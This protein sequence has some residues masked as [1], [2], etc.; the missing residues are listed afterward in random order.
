MDK[1]VIKDIKTFK[2]FL[3]ITLIL[4]GQH[5]DQLFHNLV[6]PWA[7]PFLPLHCFRRGTLSSEV[8]LEGRNNVR[9]IKAHSLKQAFDFE[10]LHEELCSFPD[11][12]CLHLSYVFLSNSTLKLNGLKQ[13]WLII[14]PNI[15]IRNS[16]RAHL[17]SSSVPYGWARL[18]WNVEED[19]TACLAFQC[20]AFPH[21]L[22]FSVRVFSFTILA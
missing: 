8:V 19:V 21:V 14:L 16:G 2:P 17:G 3:T 13:L 22:S 4:H 15:C 1:Y 10:H 9:S 20:Y 5:P 12:S 18:G 6:T 11:P 7:F